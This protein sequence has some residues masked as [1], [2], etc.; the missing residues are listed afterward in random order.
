MTDLYRI[1]YGP[2]ATGKDEAK[3]R[4]KEEGSG[5]PNV[6]PTLRK[7][8]LSMPE[9]SQAVRVLFDEVRA[10]KGENAALKR[11]LS[12]V[13]RSARMH[14]RGPSSFGGDQ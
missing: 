14:G 3:E 5:E 10:L 11:E 4:P 1:M 12:R 2:S 8:I 6:V 9:L 7:G 13:R